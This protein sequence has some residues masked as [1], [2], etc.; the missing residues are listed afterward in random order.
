MIVCPFEV[1]SCIIFFYKK[2]SCFNAFKENR[3][4]SPFYETFHFNLRP[5]EYLI[6]DHITLRTNKIELLILWF[7]CEYMNTY[8]Y[9]RSNLSVSYFG[10]KI[11]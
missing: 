9:K 1:G 11:D 5:F 4:F 7:V 3:I 8:L 10:K 6:I 2:K